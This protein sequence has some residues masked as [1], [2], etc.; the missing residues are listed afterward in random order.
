MFTIYERIKNTQRD[1]LVKIEKK[2]GR[3]KYNAEPE[4]CPTFQFF[5]K[6]MRKRPKL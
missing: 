2:W 3:I 1:V 4:D 6:L 5:D